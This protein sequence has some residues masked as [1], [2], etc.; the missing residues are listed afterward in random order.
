MAGKRGNFTR[1]VHPNL[2]DSKGTLG[3]HTRQS[4]RHTPMIVVT[5]NGGM[6]LPLPRKHQVQHVFGRGFPH[7]SGDGDDTGFCA[8]SC[9]SAEPFERRLHIRNHQK[10]CIFIHSGRNTGHHCSRRSFA[11][12]LCDKIMTIALCLEGNKQ[13]PF[14]QC[15]RIN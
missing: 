8:F 7:R 2:K 9:C 4:E 3:R 13:I 12:R 15:S 14:L 10:R 5:R 1:M 11:E 6:G